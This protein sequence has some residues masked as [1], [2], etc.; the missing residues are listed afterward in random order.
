[1]T[2]NRSLYEVL[3]LDSTATQ[4]A[5]RKSYLKLAVLL[6]PDKNPGDETA[7][8]RFQTLARVYAV[9]GDEE[10]YV[11]VTE[12]DLDD[13]EAKYRGS[14]EEKADVLKYYDQFSGDMDKVL[15][16][17]M[18]SDPGHDAH[19]FADIIADGLRASGEAPSKKFAAWEKKVRRRKA[20]DLAT[21][22]AKGGGSKKEKTK[23]NTSD[24]VALIRSRRSG[25]PSFIDALASKYGV[26]PSGDPEPSEEEFAAAAA[27]HRDRSAGQGF[28]G[29]AKKRQKA[30]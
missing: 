19:R 28:R 8:E 4:A 7:N 25:G 22:V 29:A 23:G 10:R 18:C 9:L 2:G 16:W 6:H 11:K 13:F 1:M 30:G 21:S 27:R 14:E 26:N 12:Q 3:G 15:A 5:I 24:L 17:V 20:P